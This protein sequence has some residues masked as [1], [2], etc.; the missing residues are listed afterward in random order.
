MRE[1]LEIVLIG[2]AGH[3]EVV[4][5]LGQLPPDAATLI[6][7]AE[8]ARAFTPRD[9]E[10]LAYITQTTLSVDDTAA[11]V[12]ILKAALPGHRRPAGRRTSATPPPTGRRP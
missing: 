2:H 12:A 7:T 10:R 5:T 8:D 9:P 3:P 4:G 6:E 11:I 1:G